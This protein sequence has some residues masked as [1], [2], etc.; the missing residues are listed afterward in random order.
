MIKDS[1]LKIQNSR[2]K[3]IQDCRFK[4]QDW[5]RLMAKIMKFE[6]IEAWEKA[7][8][9][10]K[11]VY[12]ACS[13]G[14]FSRDFNLR[15]QIQRAA[16]SIMSNIAEGFERGTNKEFIQFLYIAKGSAGEVRSQLYVALDLGYI[17]QDVF[18]SLN[19]D[20]LSISKQLSGFI[21]YLQSSSQR[22]RKR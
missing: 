7:R 11:K 21:Q 15:D 3:E 5:G 6:D 1:R 12:A 18:D 8:G 19:L 13:Q 9:I 16:V 14:G 10:V 20:L 22:G 4:I 17:H 2:W